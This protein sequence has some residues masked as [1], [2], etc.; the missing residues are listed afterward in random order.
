MSIHI[1]KNY[2]ENKNRTIEG[3]KNSKEKESI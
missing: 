3:K 2:E 1:L